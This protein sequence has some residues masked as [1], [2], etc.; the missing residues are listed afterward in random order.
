VPLPEDTSLD[1]HLEQHFAQ[2]MADVYRRALSEAGYNAGYFRSTLAQLGPLEAVRK[3]LAALAV[4]DGFAAL[5]ERGRM[6]LTVEAVIPT[7]GGRRLPWPAC[8]AKPIR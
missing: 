6:D 8:T 7:A 5:W 3:L 2:Q 4:S 1:S